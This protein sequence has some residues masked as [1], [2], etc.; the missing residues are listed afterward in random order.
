LPVGVQGLAQ[1]EVAYQNAAAYAKDRLVKGGRSPGRRRPGEAGET[2]HRAPIRATEPPAIRSFNEAA[3]AA[4][5]TALTRDV[6][7]SAE[8]D[9]GRRTDSMALTPVV[10]GVLTDL[11]SR[12][13]CA[14]SRSW[15]GHG[16]IEEWG[17]SQFV[18]DARIAMI[19][20]GA[21]GVQAMD[22]VGA[23]SRGTADG[24]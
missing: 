8:A 24:P 16:Y 13:P 9:A 4:L 14:P 18:R 17:M 2:D 7:P 5:W 1:S 20:E 19:Y 23:S 21:N 3:R 11:G 12:T 6:A 22:L 15:A 10:K